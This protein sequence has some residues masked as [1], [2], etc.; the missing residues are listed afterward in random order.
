MHFRCRLGKHAD[1]LQLFIHDAYCHWRHQY[2]LVAHAL[3]H[4]KAQRYISTLRIHYEQLRIAGFNPDTVDD[5]GVSNG[6]AQQVVHQQDMHFVVADEGQDLLDSKIGPFK[7]P[8]ACFKIF[9]YLIETA[10][11][12]ITPRFEE[13]GVLTLKLGGGQLRAAT[14]TSFKSRL[15]SG[16]PSIDI[17]AGEQQGVL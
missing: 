12:D 16:P 13:F 14:P 9:E 3:K 7:T 2:D 8:A 1:R 4:A 11:S 5:S 6:S 10:H 15:Q 17:A